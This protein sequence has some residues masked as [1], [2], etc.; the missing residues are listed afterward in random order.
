MRK[1]MNTRA[2]LAETRF[3]L[4]ERCDFVMRVKADRQVGFWAASRLDLDEAQSDRYAALVVESSI[5]SKDG[6]GGF[7][8]IVDDLANLEV[9][10]EQVRTQYAI[11]LAT[12][13]QHPA[14]LQNIQSTK[15][16][17]AS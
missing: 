2:E 1:F 17:L 6:R 8:K 16:H 11:V 13:K 15:A 7:N 3:V 12:L 5:S 9:H 4:A 14:I 10:Q